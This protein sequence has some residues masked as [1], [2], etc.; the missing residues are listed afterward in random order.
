MQAEPPLE[1]I[2]DEVARELAAEHP[3]L[4]RDRIM[5]SK[6]IKTRGKF[7]AFTRRG[8]L[9]VKLPSERVAELIAGGEGSP[10]DSGRG[11]PLKAWVSLRP[12]DAG[13]CARYVLEA[14]DFVAALA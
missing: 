3:D 14:R 7:C 9:V 4:E 6:G 10:F 11:R 13:T 1:A 12:A 2:F 5:H 8:E